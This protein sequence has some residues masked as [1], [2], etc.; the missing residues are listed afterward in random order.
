MGPRTGADIPGI[1]TSKINFRESGAK[2][3]EWED[4]ISVDDPGVPSIL[5]GVE[6]KFIVFFPGFYGAT[7]AEQGSKIEDHL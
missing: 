1:E 6:D 7:D 2:D 5:G 4:S 3:A